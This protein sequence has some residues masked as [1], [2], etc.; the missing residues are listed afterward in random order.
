MDKE[1][2]TC[3]LPS[4]QMYNFRVYGMDC[5]E[6]TNALRRELS[7]LIQSED[8]LQFDL[9]GGRLSVLPKDNV[10]IA[11]ILAA[12]ARTGLRATPIQQTEET[13]TIAQ[14]SKLHRYDRRVWFCLFSGIATGVAAIFSASRLFLD[15]N[16]TQHLVLL[17]LSRGFCGIGA[18][19]GMWFVFPRAINA[20]VRLRPDMNLL[21]TVAVIGALVLGEWIEAASVSF[22]FAL[23]LV[24]ESWSVDRARRAV[25]ALLQ[26]APVTARCRSDQDN[27]YTERPINEVAAGTIVSVWPGEKVPLD[28][29]VTQGVTSINEAPITGESLPVE[30]SCGAEVFAGTLNLQ[31]SFEFRVT[32]TAHDTTL[33]RIVH[34]IEEAQSRRAP[35][36]RWV[37]AFARWYTPTMMVLALFVALIPPLFLGAAWASWLYESLVLLVIACPCALIISTPVSIVAGLTSAARAGVLIKGGAY[38]EAASRLRAVALDKTGTLTLGRPEVQRI[39]PLNG[40]TEQE[41]LARA[42]ALESHS[43]HPLALA[44]LRKAKETGIVFDRAEG[45]RALPGQGGVGIIAGRE[46]WI[47]SHRLLLERAKTEEHIL[48]YANELQDAGHS[49]VIV[50]NDAHVCGLIG[51]SDALREHV[52]QVIQSLKQEGIEH[53]VMLT[54]DNK[55][56]ASAVANAVGVDEYLAELLPEEK[57]RA[58]ENLVRTYK[59]VAMIGDG[60]NDAPAMAA[61]T[62]GVAMA[63]VGSDTAIETADIAL[64]SDDLTRVP[65]IIRHSRRTLQTIRQNVAF[66]LGTKALFM[67]LTLAGVASLWLAIAADTGASLLVITN[68]LRLLRAKTSST[69]G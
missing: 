17:V 31:G 44:I 53:V 59:Y 1:K 32:R 14:P 34:M 66:A 18:L 46:F 6:E 57:V 60:V 55:K 35:T 22:L 3:C 26:L 33:A 65:W 13:D 8:D 41:L 40:H 4:R 49:L 24:L 69:S 56:T 61:A 58:V 12:I 45:F 20:A 28:G 16:E 38:L 30:K 48:D 43:D 25:S 51:I 10:S 23:S 11:E 42:A 39:V 2:I 21:M 29:V 19:F 52:S 67:I 47:G 36:E 63:A 15:L 50:G 64:M 68:A 5:A 37:D 27:E 7:R 54:G 62:I 9:L